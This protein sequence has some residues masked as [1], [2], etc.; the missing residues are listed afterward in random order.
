[1][2]GIGK[3][4]MARSYAT[5]HQQIYSAVFW[6]DA[7]TE[8][9]LKRGIALIAEQIPLPHVL[10]A[11]RRIRYGESGIDTASTAVVD[12]LCL[13]DN[14]GWLLVFDNIDGQISREHQ[15]DGLSEN[16]GAGNVGYD[17]YKYFPE[18]SHGNILITS[19]LSFLSR[20]LGA[21]AI[22]V[23]EMS[24]DEGARLLCKVSHIGPGEP[25]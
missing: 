21:T 25:G 18:V 22:Q 19:R 2:G 6:L 23:E 11:G 13:K 15:E 16:P 4:Q 12:W 9:S 1:M 17:A 5:K 24:S 14:T 10:D 20:I 8:K 3:S 7:K